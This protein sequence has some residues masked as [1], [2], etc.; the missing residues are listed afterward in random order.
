MRIIRASE[1]GTYLYCKRAWSYHNQGFEPQ[2]KIE[3]SEGS[4][5]HQEHG[6]QVL[7]A[8]VL[9]VIAWLVLAAAL[10]LVVIWLTLQIL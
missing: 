5:F 3:L 7:M 9:R 8:G 1:I 6:K 10:V 2:N 4:A